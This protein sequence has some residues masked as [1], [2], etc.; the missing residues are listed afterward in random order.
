MTQTRPSSIKACVFDAY[1][2]LFDIHAPVGRVAASLGEKA[3]PI[4]D[5]WRQKQLQ[6]TWLRT[7]MGKHADFQTITREALDYAFAA[8]GLEDE[9]TR[10]RL[11]DL[12]M[13]LDAYEDAIGALTAIRQKDHSTAIL[14]N[15]TPA[16]LAAACDSAGLSSLLDEVISIEDIA[17]YKPSPAVYQLAPNRLG[18]EPHEI[19]FVSANAWD[20]SGAASFGFQCVWINRFDMEPERLPG[21]PRA[22]ISSLAE[23]PPLL[24]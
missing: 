12:Y 7:L 13:T 2:T 22:Q 23:L 8:H 3:Q 20:I 4:S 11:M 5:L 16:M 14:S 18:V 21:T 10:I 24:G 15:G 17:I 1:G 19:C 6:Y 9:A